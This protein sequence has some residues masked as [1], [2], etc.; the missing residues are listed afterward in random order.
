MP[1]CPTAC[2]GDEW[3]EL[4]FFVKDFKGFHPSNSPKRLNRF[5]FI[6]GEAPLGKENRL[7]L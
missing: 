1:E 6:R 2:S 4:V 5:G 7:F 3:Q